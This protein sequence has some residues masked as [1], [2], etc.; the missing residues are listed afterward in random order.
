[1]VSREKTCVCALLV[2]ASLLVAAGL[3]FPLAVNVQKLSSAHSD[4]QSTPYSYAW[5]VGLRMGQKLE[6]SYEADRPVRLWI[7]TGSATPSG[8]TNIAQDALLYMDEPKASYSYTFTAPTDGFYTFYFSAGKWLEEIDS[9]V[10]A[11][12]TI[13]NP[14]AVHMTFAGLTLG[15]LGVLAAARKPVNWGKC[16]G[17]SAKLSIIL[18]STLVYSS[19][20]NQFL[21]FGFIFRDYQT[22]VEALT[23]SSLALSLAFLLLS[24]PSR[25]A[26]KIAAAAKSIKI[27]EAAWKTLFFSWVAV[28]LLFSLVMIMVGTSG[29]HGWDQL[30]N[31]RV[32]L[33]R[34][35]WDAIVTNLN[36]FFALSAVIVTGLYL[37]RALRTGREQNGLSRLEKSA[38]LVHLALF[39]S[40]LVIGL[41][42]R[43]LVPYSWPIQPFA[44]V[45][46]LSIILFPAFEAAPIGYTLIAYGRLRGH[47]RSE[48]QREW[49]VLEKA[50]VTMCTLL[51]IL[52]TTLLAKFPTEAGPTPWV[53]IY[54]I[55]PATAAAGMG[56]SAWKKYKKA[57]HPLIL[58]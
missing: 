46:P 22:V 12:A 15:F 20:T 27:K 34:G 23:I 4:F 29:G 26:V 14:Y 52:S 40:L 10:N 18:L 53:I 24:G 1:M 19:L 41:L 44:F 48:V 36:F 2:F 16:F 35:P 21:N 6:F 37:I 50:T 28:A 38:L 39:L 25:E 57:L 17:F 30:S 7:I 55:I 45:M 13:Y 49:T 3:F 9:T 32:L 33:Y 54:L 11:E 43:S 47:R 31:T 5:H 42:P 56:Y 58:Q 51:S 8:I